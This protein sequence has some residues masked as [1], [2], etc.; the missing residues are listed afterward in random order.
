MLREAGASISTAEVVERMMAQR[1]MDAGDRR[2]VALMVKR[3]GTTL[4]RQEKHG[5]VRRVREPGQA[6]AG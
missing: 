1:G 4:A 3:I 2:L 5:M 6:V